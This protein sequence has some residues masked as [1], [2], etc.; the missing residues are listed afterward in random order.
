MLFFI[1]IALYFSIQ[2]FL[3]LLYFVL[4]RQKSVLGKSGFGLL[5]TPRPANPSPAAPS[6][7]TQD[8]LALSPGCQ[9]WRHGGVA[10]VLFTD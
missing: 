1:H 6:P 3:G 2:F 5:T 7:V 8:D 4:K 10:A 9:G